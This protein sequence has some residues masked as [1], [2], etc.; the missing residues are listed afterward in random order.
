M[1]FKTFLLSISLFFAS[2]MHAA[3]VTPE[4]ARQIAD[5]I[6]PTSN[7]IDKT[8]AYRRAQ[9]ANNDGKSLIY[10]F[11][12]KNNKGYIIIAADDCSHPILGYS[13]D[14]EFNEENMPVNMRNWLEG[15]NREI[16][17]AVENNIQPSAQIKAEWQQYKKAANLNMT[18]AVSP[19]ITT[20]WDQSPYYNNL[21]PYD[22]SYGERAVTGC[23]ATAMAQVMYFWQWPKQGT[24]YHEYVHERYGKLSANFGATTYDWENMPTMLNTLSTAAQKKAIA[25]LMYHCG[26]SVDMQYDV[27]ANGGSGAYSI[28][29]DGEIQE[30]AE[31]AM[32]TYFDYTTKGYDK[33]NYINSKW[34][35]LITDELDNGRPI[36][37]TGVGTLGGHCFVC[38]GY[39]DSGYF[40]FN[41]GWSGASDGYF[42]LDALNP[43]ALGAG[44]GSGGFNEYQ[45]A[46]FVVPNDQV[47]DEDSYY[48]LQTYSEIQF[49]QD[50]IRYF[51]DLS[52]TFQ[53]AN[54]GNKNFNG[55]ISCRIY[56]NEGNY[57]DEIKSWSGSVNSGKAYT[58]DCSYEGRAK[59]VPGKYSVGIY[60]A[61]GNTEEWKLAG[62]EYF[63]SIKEFVVYYS[64]YIEPY[65]EFSL[66]GTP[67]TGEL[68]TVTVNVANF[69]TDYEFNGSLRLCLSDIET[70]Y[71]VQV[72]NVLDLSQN[73]LPAR[74]YGEYVFADTV[75]VEYGTYL[76][77]LA[78]READDNSWYY[79]GST[80]ASNPIKVIVEKAPIKPDKYEDN[81]T[82]EK[83][84]ELP[85]NFVSDQ[86]FVSVTDA[87]LHAGDDMDFFKINLEEGYDYYIQTT[88]VDSKYNDQFT[89]DA[90]VAQIDETTGEQGALADNILEEVKKINGGTYCFMIAPFNTGQK[91][92]Y[93]IQVQIR[94]EK[95]TALNDN[96]QQMLIYPNPVEN[97]LNIR[98]EN[99]NNSPKT[100][101]LFDMSGKLISSFTTADDE[102]HINI[103]T[104][105]KANYMLNITTNKETK[106]Y[107][108]IKQ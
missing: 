46:L 31:V 79:A 57:F 72:I 45:T 71:V 56:D 96:R 8:S 15:Y 107:N 94:R 105:P 103:E 40:H 70:G 30:C 27:S 68:L 86:T 91:G 78:Y 3:Q 10:I 13:L 54:Y 39:N 64:D 4:E 20:K 37:Y 7:L 48:D 102:Y 85:L 75:R 21:C 12:G 35:K 81:N 60:Y 73:P 25:T 58:L 52:I 16:K 28:S 76:L 87:N 67:M 42:L 80:V 100:I 22:A 26:V 83:S 106:T 5:N 18:D 99:D 17:Y 77:E 108:I 2:F 32:S 34:K 90:V 51:S 101:R 92:T 74:T 95:P 43:S 88:I 19:L 11:A 38:D 41:W 66:S 47:N 33:E 63:N 6:L 14:G 97:Y 98:F 9:A 82:F 59:L 24:G 65:S 61:E 69:S 55:Q 36:I 84:Y 1:K 53:L 89:V 50:T 29:Y 49:E 93:A 62:S 23:V 104:L 44:G